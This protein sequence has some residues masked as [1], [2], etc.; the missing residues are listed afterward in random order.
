MKEAQTGSTTLLD[1]GSSNSF[2]GGQ[3]KTMKAE[4]DPPIDDV[5]VE[6]AGAE[7][8]D[9]VS[10]RKEALKGKT[11]AS[12][13]ST[14]GS[15]E[16]VGDD[17]PD[18]GRGQKRET[19]VRRISVSLR[20]LVVATLFVLLLAATGVTTWLYFSERSKVE[21]QQRQAA[22]ERH[23]EQIALDYAVGAATMNFQDLNAWK[24]KLTHGTAP[25]LTDKLTKA[26][27]QMEQLLIPLQ[28]DSTAQPLV[29]KVRSDTNGV[30][31]VDTFVS[32]H[33][34][35]TQAPD[36]LQSTATYSITIDSNDNWQIS[37][38]G[39]IGAV[40]GTNK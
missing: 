1:E 2:G 3:T 10:K 33:T 18:V 29:A 37:D 11:S 17:Q 4:G 31:V 23:A 27:N 9:E 22:N 6:A 28:W 20:A 19:G 30:Y 24:S 35:T 38:V 7:D 36:N 15:S 25:R 26:A 40:G 5:D 34:K 12:E 16:E 14:D 21:T 8:A 13:K 39:G 32:V